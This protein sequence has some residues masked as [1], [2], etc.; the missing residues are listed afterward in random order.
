MAAIV[1]LVVFLLL[2]ASNISTGH[3]HVEERRRASLPVK[4]NAGFA[5]VAAHMA[6]VYQRE[7]GVLRLR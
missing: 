1:G 6:G 3:R 4:L 7:E 5:A 2:Y